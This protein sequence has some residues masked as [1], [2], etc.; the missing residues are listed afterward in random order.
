MKKLNH[1]GH[2]GTRR[3]RRKFRVQSDHAKRETA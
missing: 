3:M 1:R 2:R